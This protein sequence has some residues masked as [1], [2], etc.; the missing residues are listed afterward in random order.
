MVRRTNFFIDPE[1][2]STQRDRYDPSGI[3]GLMRGLVKGEPFFSL[4]R[5][6]KAMSEEIEE[7]WGSIDL[8]SGVSLMRKVYTGE[9]DIFMFFL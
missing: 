4:W 7:N 5:K 2:A 8:D 3:H 9:T 1:L 6:Y